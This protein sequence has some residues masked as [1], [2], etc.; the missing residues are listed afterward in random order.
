MDQYAAVLL[1][2]PPEDT[3]PDLES[4]DKAVKNHLNQVTRILKDRSADLITYGPQILELLNPAVHSLSYLAVLHTLI[5]PGLAASASREYLLEKL[6]LFM[7]SFDGLQIRYAGPHLQDVFAAVGGGQ[8]LP[9][10]VAVEILATAILK[11]DP[12]GSMLTAS[13]ILLARLA[14]G[15]NNIEPALQVVDKSIVFYPGMANRGEPQYL[16]DPA[17]P[18]PSYIAR[19]TGLTAILKPQLVMEYDLLCGM[20]YCSRRDWAKASEA[21]LRIVTFPA[22]EN[23]VNKLMVDAYKRWVLVSL[24]WK[25]K[26]VDSPSPSG[27]T[28]NRYYEILGKPYTAIA[29]LFVTDNAQALKHEVDSNAQIWQEDNNMGLMQEVLAAYQKWQVLGLQQ[30]YSKISIPEVRRETKSAETGGNLPKDEDVETL[31]QN[32]IISGM[33]HGVVEKNDDGTSFLTFLSP[34]T[35]LSEQ[36]F[37]KELARTAQRL[38]SLRPVLRATDERL[39]THKEYIKHVIKESKRDKTQQDYTVGHHFEDEVDDEDLMGGIVSTG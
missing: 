34:T 25:G 11:L 16:C 21:F 9:P 10:S 17:L 32:M 38:R 24:L 29:A 33:L 18:P 14:Y 27:H 13:H 7:I 2:F 19:E 39:G 12:T 23:G 5:L 28:A 20:M 26:Y 36:D 37:A 15:T 30:V 6:V 35:S 3:P 22:R 31:I 1:S 4:Y 8:L